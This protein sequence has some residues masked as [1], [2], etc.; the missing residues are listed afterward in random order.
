MVG[1]LGFLCCLFVV[2]ITRTKDR[3]KRSNNRS[4]TDSRNDKSNNKFRFQ[5]SALRV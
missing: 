1:Q 4:N 2:I 5:G 3:N